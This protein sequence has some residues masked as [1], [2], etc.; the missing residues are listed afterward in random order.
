MQAAN[1]FGTDLKEGFINILALQCTVPHERRKIK[2]VKW[3]AS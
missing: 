3:Q 1:W 2:M